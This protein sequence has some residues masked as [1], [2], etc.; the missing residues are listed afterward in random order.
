MQ[1]E[2]FILKNFKINERDKLISKSW[3]WQ[4]NMRRY[5]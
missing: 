2:V 3:P 4:Y 5:L 1:Y